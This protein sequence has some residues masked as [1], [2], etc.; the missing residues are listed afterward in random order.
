MLTVQSCDAVESVLLCTGGRSGRG[1]AEI[2]WEAGASGFGALSG[3]L[4][5]WLKGQSILHD[6]SLIM[7]VL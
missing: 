3:L 5:Y 7:N 2:V 6:W 1:E 4:C